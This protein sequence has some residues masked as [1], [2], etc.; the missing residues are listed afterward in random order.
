MHYLPEGI[1]RMMNPDAVGFFSLQKVLGKQIDKILADPGV[2]ETVHDTIYHRLLA[3]DGERPSKKALLEEAQTFLIAGTDTTSN[4]M[5]IGFFHVLNDPSV[6]AKLVAELKAIWPEKESPMPYDSLEK[7]PYLTGVVKESLRMS[8][9]VPVSL[10]RVL[11][12]DKDIDGISVPART[13]VGMGNFFIL[14]NKE[15][16]PEPEVFTLIGGILHRWI[17]TSCR[18]QKALARVWV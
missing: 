5:S 1:T 18:S 15:I 13:V 7:L 17:G 8:I 14:M 2:L 16:F 9:G 4:A 3:D 10:P 6:R 12:A 11:S